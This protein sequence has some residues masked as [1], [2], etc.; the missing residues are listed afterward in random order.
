M[1]PKHSTNF[2]IPPQSAPNMHPTNGRAQIMEQQNKSQLPWILHHQSQRNKISGSN[3]LLEYSSTI[4]ALWTALCYHPSTHYQSNNQVQLKIQKLQLLISWTMQPP[5]RPRLSNIKIAIW[6][7]KLTVMHHTYQSQGHAA[8]LGGRYYLSSL[9]TDPKKSPNL[10]P[11]ANGPIHT[12]CI[13]LEHVVGGL[14]IFSGRLV[15][16]WGNSAPQCGCVSL[17]LI[18]MMHHCQF[19][20]S[21]RYLYI[22]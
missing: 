10:P 15:V 7:F 12:E 14:E 20:V 21:Y 19:E 4:T 6:Y 17:A 5:I 8:A 18:C 3:K 11:P 22:G 1:W 2:N 16:S 9:P 13:I